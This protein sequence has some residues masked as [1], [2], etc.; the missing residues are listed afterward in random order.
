VR[1]IEAVTGEETLDALYGAEARLSKIG[2]ALKVG[3]AGEILTRLE[4]QTAELRELRRA[5]EQ[6]RAQSA[7][8]LAE[9][10]LA[11]ATDSEGLKIVRYQWASATDAPAAGADEMRKLGDALRDREP[12]VVALFVSSTADEK[13]TFF[14]AC[15]KEAIASGVKA[16]D[17]IKRVSALAGGSGGGKPESAMG[18]GKLR[19]LFN[20]PPDAVPEFIKEVIKGA[21]K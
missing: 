21:A 3:D 6:S 10:L 16:G 7:N 11:E 4:Q 17:L 15:G 19:E 8:S 12:R 1:R 9:S 20:I 14:A 2:A 5:V 13:V 18:G